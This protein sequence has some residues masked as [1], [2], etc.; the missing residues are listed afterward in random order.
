MS[1]P[2]DMTELR[3]RLCEVF[4]R[5]QKDSAFV[6]MAHEASNAAGKII[7]TVS[8]QLEYASQRKEKPNV[9]FAA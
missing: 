6:T 4:D 8:T 3:E 7:K 9:P 5:V 2:K 1:K